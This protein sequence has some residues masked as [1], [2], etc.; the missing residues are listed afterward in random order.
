MR[1]RVRFA[2]GRT[3]KLMTMKSI[4]THLHLPLFAWLCIV[5][6]S[7]TQAFAANAPLPTSVERGIQLL[8]NAGPGP[9]VEAWR[10]GGMLEDSGR[11]QNDVARFK[12]L[13]RPLRNYQSY[14]VVEVKEIGKTSKI[15]YVAMAFERGILYGSFLVW[16][17]EHGWIVQRTDFST[18]PENIMPWL[19]QA[20]A[21]GDENPEMPK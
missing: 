13:I 8:K 19:I 11:T 1:G 18:R 16:K 15:L 6:C 10:E 5:P 7:M 12:A 3:S 20:N 14:E 21:P 4:I 2:G 9:A 17:S